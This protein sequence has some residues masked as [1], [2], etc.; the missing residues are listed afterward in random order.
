M[1]GPVSAH[2]ILPLRLHH[3]DASR[4][5]PIAVR[6][7]SSGLFRRLVVRQ[8]GM[9]LRESA[10]HAEQS[11]AAV[12]RRHDSEPQSRRNIRSA[13]SYLHGSRTDLVNSP[14]CVRKCLKSSRESDDRGDHY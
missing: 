9:D 13:L 6:R 5:T 3:P 4:V 12:Q 2:F 7:K 11:H 14:E 1:G 10:P 8:I